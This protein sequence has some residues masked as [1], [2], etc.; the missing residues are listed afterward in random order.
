MTQI[1]KS[2]EKKL[3]N[4]L[5]INEMTRL[6]NRVEKKNQAIYTHNRS[7]KSLN[8]DGSI[9]KP[10]KKRTSAT[11][12]LNSVT[13]ALRTKLL[14][15]MNKDQQSIQ[16]EKKALKEAQKA[17]DKEWQEIGKGWKD[18]KKEWKNIEQKQQPSSRVT[19]KKQ[20]KKQD[21]KIEVSDNSK[22]NE[23]EVN[24]DGPLKTVSKKGEFEQLDPKIDN[25]FVNDDGSLV[26]GKKV[27]R[28][29]ISYYYN[30]VKK[31]RWEESQ[32]E[33]DA[34][35]DEIRDDVQEQAR[36]DDKKY[37]SSG[38]Q[39]EEVKITNIDGSVTYHTNK[40]KHLYISY[41][42]YKKLN[43]EVKEVNDNLCVP[44]F[45][46]ESLRGRDSFKTLTIDKIINQFK[47]L[48][49]DVNN[50]ISIDDLLKW[51]DIKYAS[52]IS[53][54]LYDGFDNLIKKVVADNGKYCMM[55]VVHNSH[56]YGIYNDEFIRDHINSQ[57]KRVNDV[58][59]VKFDRCDWTI[60]YN[61]NEYYY[62]ANDDDIESCI[63]GK[64]DPKYRVIVLDVDLEMIVKKII[65]RHGLGIL[66]NSIKFDSHNVLVAFVH[67]KTDQVIEFNNQYVE[68]KALANKLKE[69]FPL[70]CFDYKN[71]SLP[72]IG[73]NLMEVLL[74]GKLPKSYYCKQDREIIDKYHTAPLIATFVKDHIVNKNCVA[75]D[76]KRSYKNATLQIKRYPVYHSLNCFEK[77]DGNLIEETGEYLVNSFHIAQLGVWIPKSIWSS[78]FV[79]ALIKKG[80]L[81]KENI[82]LKR[83]ASFV[84]DG[85]I[86]RDAFKKMDTIVDDQNNKF[87]FNSWV[88]NLGKRYNTQKKGVI[89]DDCK[90]VAC[91]VNQYSDMTF[92][93]IGGFY[94]CK[95]SIK[96]RLT[97]DL[98]TFYRTILSKA[99]LNL[100]KLAEI[101][102]GVGTIVGW[103][104]DSVFIDG[105]KK[106]DLEY[107]DSY[108]VEEWKPKK[109]KPQPIDFD[110]IDIDFERPVN[111]IE[112]V[113]FSGRNVY[114][115]G[116]LVH[117][118]TDFKHSMGVFGGA[119]CQKSTLLKWINGKSNDAYV[120]SFTNKAV[121]NLKDSVSASNTL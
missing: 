68:C 118:N 76:I 87:M 43:G 18:I 105:G 116:E 13:P 62:C 27:V 44:R 108:R 82:V 50:G 30:G 17:I 79:H 11:D 48:G 90:T 33:S 95:R 119:G 110:D 94:Y 92:N 26:N 28:I 71:Q 20:V 88:G 69:Q 109:F 67:P 99:M 52:T 61:S 115:G 72:S 37:G 9:K 74:N 24:V 66:G 4:Y 40:N 83:R 104:T 6:L 59:K 65:E 25:M 46:Y 120:T 22:H 103:N 36:A 16:K 80:F 3:L 114:Q 70:H 101:S 23:V 96:T 102:K 14:N 91:L 57:S 19:K 97:E 84:F 78:E 100:I 10:S 112:D 31:Y 63:D 64:I 49:M 75:Y 93:E 47:E 41:S 34:N 54:Y 60:D 58:K 42:V 55:G 15:R 121:N 38:S 106:L 1:E 117:S 2:T 45:I 53:L 8:H 39:I 12:L 73:M 107:Y 21:K 111:K 81:D 98:D 113:F 29:Q 56:V 51:R 85:R 89:T 7:D 86:I 35:I 5:T 77:F 32:I